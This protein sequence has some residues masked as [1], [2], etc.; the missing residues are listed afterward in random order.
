MTR[1]Y[2]RLTAWPAW[3]GLALAG[4]GAA[5]GYTRL[6]LTDPYMHGMKF[7]VATFPAGWKAQGSISR[8][9]CVDLG[10][11]PGGAPVPQ[12]R[13]ESADGQMQARVLP[14]AIWQWLIGSSQPNL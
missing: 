13:A 4:C 12:L 1:Q 2:R 6:V 5:Q 7:G 14:E 8:V 10:G 9:R 11:T 3:L